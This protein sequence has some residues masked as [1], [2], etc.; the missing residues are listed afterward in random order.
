[1]LK[2]IRIHNYKCFVDFKLD[3]PQMSAIVG[4]NGSG[5]TSLWEVL[6]G[7]QDLVVR[8]ADVA[9]AFPTRTLSRWVKG[10]SVQRF[11]LDVEEAESASFRYELEVVH[12]ERRKI[13][14]IQRETLTR[15]GVTMQRTVDGVVDVQ[16]SRELRSSKLSF[17]RKMSYVAAIDSK[18]GHGPTVAF[19][20]ILANMWLIAPSPK[21]LQSTTTSEA[22][23]LDRDGANF[24][25]WFRGIVVE[26][27]EII[28]QLLERLQPA[29]HGLQSITF[30]RLST[31]VRE[32]MFTFRAG[33]VD[34]KLSAGELSDGQKSLLFLYGFL[35]AALDKPAIVFIDEPETGLAPHEMQPWIS[36]MARAIE[37]HRGQVFI[38]SHHP[39]FI[40]YV[41]AAHTIQFRRDAL[42]HAVT[43][44]VTLETTHGSRVSEWISRPWAYDDDVFTTDDEENKE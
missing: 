11:V 6:A 27:P 23:W 5:K 21:A 40:D 8:G 10:D 39:E 37:D 41:A 25:S 34:Y 20:N 28:G 36:A 42:G 1:M 3:L 7:L 38:A 17:S 18:D 2:Q 4:S 26:R 24:A 43:Q 22:Y 32:L 19:R 13:P 12:D 30:E 33:D 15:N 16:G 14:L 29:L 44:D 9:S 31:E 35:L